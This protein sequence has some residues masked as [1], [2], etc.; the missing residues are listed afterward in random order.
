M[1]QGKRYNDLAAK[2]VAGHF[3]ITAGVTQE[4]GGGDEGPSPHEILEAALAACTIITVQMYANRKG[5]KLES[6]DVKITIDSESKTES[7]ISRELTFKGELDAEQ[8][9]RLFEIAEKC[10]IHNLLESHITIT[11]TMV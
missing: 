3:E 5:W 6:T 8:K 11:S 2:I 1:V 4:K 9:Q 7:K 10:P